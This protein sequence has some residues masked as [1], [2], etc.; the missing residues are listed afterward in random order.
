MVF[1]SLAKDSNYYIFV[2]ENESVL[3]FD[4]LDKD[5]IIPFVKDFLKNSDTYAIDDDFLK[6]F[7]LNEKDIIL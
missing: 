4:K 3:V 2:D 7:D 5:F 6:D 1:H